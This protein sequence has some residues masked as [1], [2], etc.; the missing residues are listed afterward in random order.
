MR[1]DGLFKIFTLIIIL[2]NLTWAQ[3]V[4]VKL[5]QGFI[6]GRVLETFNKA[7]YYAFQQI[8]YADPPIGELRFKPPT[9]PSMWQGVLNTT[10]NTKICY[11]IG[12]EDDRENEDCLYLNVYTPKEP[13][14]EGILPVIV[15]VHGGAFI[16]GNSV[17]E[18]TGPEFLMDYNVV[19]VTV[20]YR[21]GAFGFLSTQDEVIPG[22]NGLKDI[23]FALEWVK[24]YIT[25][26]GGNPNKVTLAGQSAGAALVGYHVISEKS[27]GLFRAAIM[28]SGSAL[29]SWAYQ[30][31][32]RKY[33]Y[34]LA[35]SINNN[36]T[37]DST[38]EELLKFLQRVSP[39]EINN[40]KFEGPSGLQ[41]GQGDIFAPVIEVKHEGAFITQFMHTRLLTGRFNRVPTLIGVNSEE[42]IYLAGDI[43]GFKN[44]MQQYDGNISLIVNED[45]NVKSED[46]IHVGNMIRNIYT[47]R[48][49]AD[50]LGA[51]IRFRS[52]VRYTTAIA[53]QAAL[54]SRYSEVYFYEF[55][56]HG[57]LGNNIV[58]EGA[59][60]VAHSEELNFLWSNPNN[61]D[62]TKYPPNDVITLLR[63][64]KLWTQFA[65]Y[66]NPTSEEIPLLQDVD[67]PEVSPTNFSYLEIGEELTIKENP[68]KYKEWKAIIDE[69]GN[70]PFDTY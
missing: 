24:T 43:D 62:I 50:D 15:Y 45:Y 17:L 40:A 56:Y 44:Q 9:E 26:F 55:S 4:F 18:S 32:S 27:E 7:K 59:G 52:D 54:Q 29:C 14:T 58:V 63:M 64:L 25:L 67:W 13:V 34:Q 60:R 49:F 46:L 53:A 19:V 37:A 10:E 11:Q 33:A 41:L 20:Q 28:E 12:V 51:S 8:P 57:F 42:L 5:P 2:A 47:N 39:Q 3:E 23:L 31:Y 48:S 30:R 69:F 16:M 38:S 1:M 68:K 70:G 6:R 22:N 21:L 35:S 66:M 61:K 65:T 36:F